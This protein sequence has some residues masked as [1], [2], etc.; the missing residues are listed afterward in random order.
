[1]ET[2]EERRLAK[3]LPLEATGEPSDYHW[4]KPVDITLGLWALLWSLIIPVMGLIVGII[5]ISKGVESKKEAVTTLGIIA[6]VLSFVTMGLYIFGFSKVTEQ[7]AI[8]AFSL[9]ASETKHTDS[10]GLSYYTPKNMRA[11]SD[12]SAGALFQFGGSKDTILPS[13]EK[14]ITSADMIYPEELE[15]AFFALTNESAIDYYLWWGRILPSYQGRYVKLVSQH[16][17]GKVTYLD[18]ELASATNFITGEENT[19]TGPDRAAIALQEVGDAV[20]VQTLQYSSL[21]GYDVVT[22]NTPAWQKMTQS[23]EYNPKQKV[24]E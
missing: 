7:P 12:S 23:V 22:H 5:A 9:E 14:Y 13:Q 11:I 24:E 15:K 4:K 6:I 3:T 16:H 2:Q 8:N 10:K 21:F 17:Q 18:V 20:V 19:D 1:M